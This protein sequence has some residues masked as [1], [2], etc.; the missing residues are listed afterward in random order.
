MYPSRRSIDSST[1]PI[2]PSMT[3][4]LTQTIFKQGCKCISLYF[5]P[6]VVLSYTAGTEM[7]QA[8]LDTKPNVDAE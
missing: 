1:K 7:S 3:P 4:G 2:D 8:F 5:D 6:S